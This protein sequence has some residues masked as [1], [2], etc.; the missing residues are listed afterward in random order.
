[1]VLKNR[2]VTAPI[3]NL[4][5]AK[6]SFLLKT[7]E[8]LVLPAYK[9]STLRG[10]FGVVFRQICCVNKRVNDCS[11]CLLKE[12]CVYVYIFETSPSKASDKLKNLTEIPRPFVIEPPLETKTVYNKDETLEF[13]LIL[14]GRAI[15]YLPYFIFTFRELG[16]TGIG[17]GRKKFELFKVYNFSKEKVYDE[18]DEVIRNIDSRINFGKILKSFLS[19]ADNLSL[20]FLTPTRIK[21]KDDL[22]VKP[23]FHII[24]RFLL[25]RLSALSYFHCGKE[26]E[27]NY[28]LLISQAENVRIKSENLTWID[29]ERYSSR[30]DT[31]M[32]LGGFVGTIT[33]EGDFKEFL[34]LLLI[35]QYTHIGKNCTFGLGKYGI[36]KKE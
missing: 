15:D 32:K 6:Y 33:Y 13:N 10:G 17:K 16:K 25:H 1:M 5:I 12:K 24:L 30:Q 3:N 9:G 36:S 8:D 2:E 20:S 23:E 34:P 35:G 27:I 31:R 28:N 21:F 18:K 26:L 14:I 29:W 11:S 19:L 22:V 7:K 4:D